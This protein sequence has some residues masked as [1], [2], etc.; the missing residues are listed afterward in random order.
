LPI[1]FP[2]VNLIRMKYICLICI[3]FHSSLNAQINPGSR[4]KALGSAGTALQDVWSLQ[5]NC[6]GTASIEHAI[7]ALGYEQHFLNPELS[8]QTAVFGLPVRNYVVGLSLQRYGIT[9]Y[10]EQTTGLALSRNFSG[11]LAISL[12]LKYHQV[13]IPLYGSGQAFSVDAGMQYSLNDKI[14]LGSYISNPGRSGINEFSGSYIPSGIAVGIAVILSD[15][16]LLVSDLNKML[17]YGMNVRFGVEYQIINWFYLRGGISSNPF[18]QSAGF[19]LKYGKFSLDA[20]VSSQ[21]I[22]GYSPNL[23]FS[24]EF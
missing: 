1:L 13:N 7:F 9:E 20:A 17:D 2:I 22:L 4:S 18:K 12:G 8:T 24:Y 6:A 3:L 21:P 19:G 5:Q 14:R 11:A 23:S 16:V 15:K 10:R